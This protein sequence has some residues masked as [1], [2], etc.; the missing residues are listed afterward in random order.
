MNERQQAVVQVNGESAPHVDELLDLLAG[1]DIGPGTRG[2]AV[3]VNGEIVPR[4]R[5]REQRL[6]PGDQIDIV[7]AVQGG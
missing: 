2:V 6:A 1:H 3:A 7:G 5:W 4:D